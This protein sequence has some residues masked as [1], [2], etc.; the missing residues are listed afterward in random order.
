MKSPEEIAAKTK[1]IWDKMSPSQRMG[2]KCGMFPEA[3]MGTS[4]IEKEGFSK[5]D[6]HQIVVAL[7]KMK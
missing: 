1:E 6:R 3:L 5:D 4:L 2:A 7:M